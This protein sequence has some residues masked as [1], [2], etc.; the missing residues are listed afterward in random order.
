MTDTEH[1]LFNM[2]KTS[3]AHGIY[4]YSNY[5]CAGTPEI[6]NRKFSYKT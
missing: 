1:T 4:N 6:E 5:A 2:V 3:L